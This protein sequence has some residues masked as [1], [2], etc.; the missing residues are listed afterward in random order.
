MVAVQVGN[1][2]AVNAPTAEAAKLNLPLG[3]FSG[4]QQQAFLLQHHHK[5][6]DI[7]PGRGRGGTGAQEDEVHHVLVISGRE[8]GKEPQETGVTSHFLELQMVWL[9]NDLNRISYSKSG[10]LLSTAPSW[11]FSEPALRLRSRAFPAKAGISL[12]NGFPPSR[13]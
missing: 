10:V 5:G 6:G 7:A 12:H 3:A 1:E 13:D 4:V 9:S 2:D 11:A 8:C